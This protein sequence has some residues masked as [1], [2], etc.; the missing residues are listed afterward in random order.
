MTTRRNL[1][2]PDRLV[3]THPPGAITA[4]FLMLVFL[5]F[6]SMAG[7]VKD[8]GRDAERSCSNK[9]SLFIDDEE[10]WTRSLGDLRKQDDVVNFTEGKQKGK[11][12]IP[13]ADLMLM[14]ETYRR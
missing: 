12:G 6:G 7:E 4:P 14:A 9:V 13:L 1:T 2:R 10:Q 11:Q 3:L 8:L 5:G